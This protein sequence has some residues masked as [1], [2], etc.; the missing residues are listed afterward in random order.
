MPVNTLLLA[1]NT[2][3]L[4][5]DQAGNIA[6]AADPYAPAQDASSACRV[7]LGEEWYNTTAGSPFLQQ[8]FGFRPPASLLKSLLTTAALTTPEV[9]AATCVLTSFTHRRIS[10]QLQLTLQSG[11]VV[12]IGFNDPL[13][14]WYVTAVSPMAAGS[15][16]GGP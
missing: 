4:S 5:V 2:W 6:L 10:G 12:A 14:N 8:I 11:V 7:F 16:E 9:V 13:A 3:D 15:L 1:L